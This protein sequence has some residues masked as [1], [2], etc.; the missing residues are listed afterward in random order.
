[1]IHQRTH[2]KLDQPGCFG[3]RIA[4]VAIAPSATGSEHAAQINDTE[5]RWSKDHAAYKRLVADGLQPKV[6]DGAAE[7]ERRATR[8][9]EITHGLGAPDV[10]KEIHV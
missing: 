7:L 1:M 2:P 9:V 4:S 6:L 8:D 5:R 10:V 3:C